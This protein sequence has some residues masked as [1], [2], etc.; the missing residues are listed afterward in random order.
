MLAGLYLD[1]AFIGATSAR[2]AL[3]GHA[4]ADLGA[5]QPGDTEVAEVALG[6]AQLALAQRLPGLRASYADTMTATLLARIAAVLANGVTRGE[7]IETL[8][9]AILD[10]LRDE[11]RAHRIALTELTSAS[12]TVALA[13][14]RLAGIHSTLWATDENPCP[15]CIE[16]EN[17]GPIPVGM[18]FASGDLAPPAHPNCRCAPI[19]VRLE[20]SRGHA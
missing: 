16:N 17:Q 2:A 12:S 13:V 15:V 5:W 6:H 8:A 20:V 19:P 11:Q 14:Y 7:T 3:D 9:R 4:A 10:E 18:P 1:G